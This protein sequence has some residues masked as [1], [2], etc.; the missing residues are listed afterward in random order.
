MLSFGPDVEW[1]AVEVV[2][3][4]EVAAIVADVIPDGE[5]SNDVWRVVPL[6]VDVVTPLNVDPV[7]I[8]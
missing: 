2:L 8:C 6:G 7:D 3:G 5:T 4:A 1:V